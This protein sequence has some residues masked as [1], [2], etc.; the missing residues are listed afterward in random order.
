MPITKKILDLFKEFVHP[1]VKTSTPSS[2]IK[3]TR[4]H[5]SGNASHKRCV[6][7]NCQNF[8]IPGDE[9]CK[10]HADMR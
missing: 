8:A 1:R 6:M 10:D 7:E 2:D 9:V 5:M 3:P 4:A